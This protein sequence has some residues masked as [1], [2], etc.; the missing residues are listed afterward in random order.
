[1]QIKDLVLKS[2]IDLVSDL[3]GEFLSLIALT[4]PI[5]VK[6]TNTDRPSVPVQDFK[7]AAR[8]CLP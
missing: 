7:G 2:T 1:M 5:R 6:G 3:K 8:V 4:R